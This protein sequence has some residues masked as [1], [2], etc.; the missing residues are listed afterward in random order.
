MYLLSKKNLIILNVFFLFLY[1]EETRLTLPDIEEYQLDNGMRVLISPNYDNPIVYIYMYLKV[2]AIDSPVDKPG[3]AGYTFDELKHGTHKYPSKSEVDEKLFSF[4]NEDGTF[5]YYALNHEFGYIENYCLKEDTREC[6]ELISEVLIKP[7]LTFK[8]EFLKGM[9][10]R[11]APK[12]LFLNEWFLANEH[13]WN[14]YTNTT[15]Y[16]SPLKVMAYNKQDSKDWYNKYIRPENMTLMITGDVN[17]IYIKKII[18]EYFGDWESTESLPNK[19]DY[20]INLTKNT[21]IKLRFINFEDKK[22][23][24]KTRII[25][26]G[27]SFVDNW[28]AEGEL[29]RRVLGDKPEYSRLAKIHNKFNKSGDLHYDRHS[30]SRVPYTVIKSNTNYSDLSSY[31]SEIVS[32]FSKLANNSITEKE[33]E[34]AKKEKINGWQNKIYN[35]ESF[36]TFI[37]KFYNNGYSLNDISE[38]TDRMKEVTLEDV[39]SAAK[40]MFDPNNFMMVVVGNKDSCAAFLEQFENYEY[41]EQTDEIRKN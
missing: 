12:K 31:Y 5:K 16:F 26:W 7:T 36:S 4:G 9:L 14:L 33:L 22:D 32:E 15:V 20:T 25:T 10:I 18:N 39:N 30:R 1:A 27:P 28:W 38:L 41:Y 3:L 29:A 40:K 19:R 6:L 37:Q 21:G 17:Y 34:S 23:H 35:I 13:I 11:L 2:G 24:A 8:K